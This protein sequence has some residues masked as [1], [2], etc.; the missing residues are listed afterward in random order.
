[1]ADEVKEKDLKTITEETEQFKCVVQKVILLL[2][3]FIDG[4][5]C[6]RC[7]PCPMAA[8]ELRDIY[9]GLSQGRGTQENIEAI[10]KITP[11][12]FD[13]SMCKKGKDVAKFITDSLESAE[14]TYKHVGHVCPERECKTL[15]TYKVVA[16]KCVMCNDCKDVCKDFA[17]LGEKKI[18]YLSGYMPYEIV[19]KRCT[20][21]GECLTAC[22]YGAIEVVDCEAG[23]AC[24]CAA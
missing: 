21:C 19:D 17:I 4:P 22:K 13:T 12:M 6:A 5:M 8:Y 1:M 3:E 10:K 24:S 9:V 14:D 18:P 7:M 20:R 15:Y 2:N 16:K 11:L 23:A